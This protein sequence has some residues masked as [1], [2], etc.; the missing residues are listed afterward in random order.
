MPISPCPE[1]QRN[2]RALR[3]CTASS[4]TCGPCFGDTGSPLYDIDK[5][6]TVAVLVAIAT[7]GRFDSFNVQNPFC[8]NE[9]IPIIY[10]TVAPYVSWIRET[11]GNATLSEFFVPSTGINNVVLAKPKSSFPVAARTSIIVVCTLV[12]A[13]LLGSLTF[14]CILRHMRAR[15]RRRRTGL[16]DED[17]FINSRS[18]DLFM[19]DPFEGIQYQRR[20]TVSI[21]QLSSNAI[22]RLKRAKEFSTR[23]LAAVRAKLIKEEDSIELSREPVPN[24]PEWVD[25][26]WDKLFRPPSKSD[27]SSIHKVPT[28]RVVDDV[29]SGTDKSVEPSLQEVAFQAAREEANV[30]AAWQRLELQTS[31][32]SMSETASANLSP[33]LSPLPQ[34]PP[35]SSRGIFGGLS[36]SGS[37]RGSASSSPLRRALSSSRPLPGELAK[38]DTLLAAFAPIDSESE[39]VEETAVDSTAL[40]ALAAAKRPNVVNA[41]RRMFSGSGMKDHNSSNEEQSDGP[42]SSSRRG[43]SSRLAGSGSSAMQSNSFSL[44]SKYSSARMEYFSENYSVSDSGSEADG[45]DLF[46]QAFM[47]GSRRYTD[48]RRPNFETPS[49]PTI[50]SYRKGPAL[51]LYELEQHRSNSINEEHGRDLADQNETKKSEAIVVERER[52]NF[53]SSSAAQ[54]FDPTPG[55]ANV[56]DESSTQVQVL[57]SGYQHNIS[58]MSDVSGPDPCT[59]SAVCFEQSPHSVVS[60]EVGASQTNSRTGSFLH[61]PELDSIRFEGNE[62]T[63]AFTHLQ[64]LR[65]NAPPDIQD[66]ITPAAT[67]DAKYKQSLRFSSPEQKFPLVRNQNSDEIARE[68]GAKSTSTSQGSARKYSRDPIHDGMLKKRTTPTKQNDNQVLEPGNTEEGSKVLRESPAKQLPGHSALHAGSSTTDGDNAAVKRTQRALTGELPD[69]KPEL[70]LQLGRNEAQSKRISYTLMPKDAQ[71]VKDSSQG[72][73]SVPMLKEMWNDRVRRDSMNGLE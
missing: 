27:F 14:L 69:V 26:A 42:P 54:V 37:K 51:P 48:D 56:E 70:P 71:V 47:V 65:S 50:G 53:R 28:Q 13:G 38:A 57:W 12:L 23:S 7:L 41:L 25:T 60:P 52:E 17:S 55:H 15:R 43:I 44:S 30:E 18:P 33:P 66:S 40:R 11:M 22:E 58:G 59:S 21:S 10:T 35:S 2:D 72:S 73:I 9:N 20:P 61:T 29:L 36:R 31:L 6:G 16:Q 5:S 4:S 24:A 3:I 68:R 62:K 1:P 39:H 63:E 64:N 34:S 67:L 49:I 19:P 8:T 32:R 45:T 46:D